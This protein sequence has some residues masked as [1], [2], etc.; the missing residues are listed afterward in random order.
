MEEPP[1]KLESL[2]GGFAA[3]KGVK[4]YLTRRIKM[5]H[6]LITLPKLW[7]FG[8]Q[9]FSTSH[10]SHMNQTIREMPHV[11]NRDRV[12]ERLTVAGTKIRT[13]NLSH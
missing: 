1:Y 6:N 4:F 10:I 13:H 5:N 12:S 2:E 11:R 7:L 3:S 9:A 8:L